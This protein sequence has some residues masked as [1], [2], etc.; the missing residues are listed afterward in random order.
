MFYL[1]ALK[2]VKLVMDGYWVETGMVKAIVIIFCSV[3]LLFFQ[4]LLWQV[5]GSSTSKCV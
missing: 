4:K 3:L 1:G 2:N 5:V